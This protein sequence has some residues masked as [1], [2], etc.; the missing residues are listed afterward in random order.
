[1]EIEQIFL[2]KPQL[3]LYIYL[4]QCSCLWGLSK[5]YCCTPQFS[6]CSSSSYLQAHKCSKVYQ[7]TFNINASMTIFCIKCA[8]NI[9]WIFTTGAELLTMLNLPWTWKE[10]THTA[11]LTF[12]IRFFCKIFRLGSYPLCKIVWWRPFSGLHTITENTIYRRIKSVSFHPYFK[13]ISTIIIAKTVACTFNYKLL[14]L[15]THP[16]VVKE[17]LNDAA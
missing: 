7:D 6:L 11:L 4:S 1:M 9:C 16:H 14:S 2:Y 17:Y 8:S 5:L 10:R 3:S 13:C 15:L 12:L